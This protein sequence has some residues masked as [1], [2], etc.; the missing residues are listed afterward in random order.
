[1]NKYAKLEGEAL[2][3]HL[4]GFLIPHWSVSAISSF[5]G[6]EK[7][8]EQ[9]Y[10]Y[11]DYPKERSMPSIIG[12]AY[13]H[14]LM[15]YFRNMSLGGEVLSFD[16]LTMIAHTRLD[17]IGAD[18]Y[19][20]QKKLT[21]IEQQLKAL[22]CINFALRSFL[23]E[24]GAYTS[25]IQEILFVEQQFKEFVSINGIDIPIPL[26][27]VPDLVFIDKEGYLCILDHKTVYSYTPEKNVTKKYSNQSIGYTLAINEFIRRNP[28]M[29][30]KWPK[31]KEG[32][33]HFYYYENK[34]S[35]NRD[36]SRQIRQIPMDLEKSGQLFE[37][38]LF[39]GVFRLIEAV[40]NPDYV[41]LMNPNDVMEDGEKIL[42]FWIK[43]HI[44][45]LEGFPNLTP[46][47]RAIL[48]KRRSNVRRAALTSIPKS[49]IKA[50]TDPTDFVSLTLED[51][52]NLTIPEKIEH[53][54]KTFGYPVKV[55][56]TIEGYSCDTHLVQIGAGLKSSQIYGYRM[57][58]ANAVGAKDVRINKNLVEYKGTAYVAIEVNR[59]NTRPLLLT[60]EH[61][62]AK[63]L[64]FPVGM[65]NFG[66]V[67][68][69]DIANPSTPHLLV[70]GA[71]GS[72]KS[73][74]IESIIATAMDKHIP[75]TILDPKYEFLHYGNIARVINE[76]EDIEA[77][78]AEK[79]AEM[80]SIFKAKGAVGASK[81]KQLIIFDES[82][83]CFTRQTKE[84]RI[85][86]DECGEEIQ[87]PTKSIKAAGDAFEAIMLREE[88][89]EY[90]AG[91]KG[92][93]PKFKTLEENTL[94]L[95][96]KARSA[97]IHLVLAA[98]RF[99]VKV[100]TGDAKANFTTRLCLTV[101]S[102]V[103]SKVMLDQEGAEKLNG[104][105]DALITSPEVSEPVRIQCFMPH[106]KG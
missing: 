92:K 56:H 49:V 14:A 2:E 30:K 44:D 27:A 65:D 31:A 81:D 43:T 88:W 34:Y 87:M 40:Q 93:D 77:F 66:N 89:A 90:N 29:F 69:W 74:L 96:Q 10:I 3:K 58:I 97:G 61:I 8:F 95:A 18:E 98:Q 84:R 68:R 9:R 38:I 100:L 7:S 17:S 55:E 26:K 6:N 42:E 94:I 37:Q 73:V 24:L 47:Q 51:T 32:V 15:E 25:V 91:K 1:M 85:V 35:Q 54:L 72:G 105:G 48:T 23:G 59:K 80:D 12:E 63:E 76:L 83:D 39:E 22:E 86:M 79:V 64:G 13:H 67:I 5:I 11:K 41:Y 57:D 102:G 99:S 104:K 45:G 52:E 4:E 62:R 53:R 33:K 46:A 36:G 50:F 75:V 19:R 78:M 106:Q 16:A 20:P 70:A 21:I 101:A 71:S 28:N 60:E 82:A 103:D